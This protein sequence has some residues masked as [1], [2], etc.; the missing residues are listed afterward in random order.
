MSPGSSTESYPA[1]ARI[2]LR[3]NPGK[4]LNQSI[5]KRNEK[6]GGILCDEKVAMSDHKYERLIRAPKSKTL[7]PFAKRLQRVQTQLFVLRGALQGAMK[8][9]IKQFSDFPTAITIL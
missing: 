7:I 1:F 5:D 9:T 4:N 2:G 3:E 6:K 8:Q